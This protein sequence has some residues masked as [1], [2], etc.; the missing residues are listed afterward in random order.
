MGNRH[1]DPV[2][3]NYELPSYHKREPTPPRWNGRHTNDIS[4][5]EMSSSKVR[6]PD[7]NYTRDP[8]DAADIEYSCPNYGSRVLGRGVSASRVDRSL[9]VR[10]ITDTKRVHT[11]QTN[12]L[13]PVYKVPTNRTTSLTAMFSEEQRLGVAA[14]SKEAESIG[15]VHGSRPR[16]LHWDNGEPHLS[17][18]REDIAG[19]VPQRFVGSVPA[20]IYDPPDVRPAISFH[21]PH[22]IPGAQ[23][24][25]L[26]KGIETGRQLD[27]LNP[28]YKLLDGDRMPHPVPVF[29][30]ERGS[31]HHIHPMLQQRQGGGGMA[32]APDLLSGR[33]GSGAGSVPPSGR[34][35]QPSGRSMPR[36]ASDGALRSRGRT[37]MQSGLPS[38][39]ATPAS[40]GGPGRTPPLG[41][42]GR[43][44]QGH[45]S[46][47]PHGAYTPGA[48]SRGSAPGSYGGAPHLYG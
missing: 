45:F 37:P 21:D 48:S 19:A 12:P 7:R 4:D 15:E 25:S 17:L 8:N 32:S 5:I 11:R 14:P 39:A 41:G 42:T 34:G 20:N 30:A 40:M 27:P 36:N 18:L 43:G 23:V 13:E 24:S 47:V 35:S 9:N 44:A 22:D 46:S 6:I 29:E 3:P 10:D 31:A 33:I 38:G 2:C 1:V 16:K 26:R 28:K